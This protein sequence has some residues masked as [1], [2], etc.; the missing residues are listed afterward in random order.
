MPVTVQ[1]LWVL[2]C[3]ILLSACSVQLAPGY[4]AALTEGLSE[5]NGEALTLFAALEEGSPASEF[6]NYQERYAEL[7]GGFDG[8]RQRAEARPVP[9][10]AQRLARHRIVQGFC[11]SRDDP[12]A[13]LN[14]SPA[15][16]SEIVS[17]LRQLRTRHRTNG[18]S[19]A[20]VT[21]IRNGYDVAIHQALTVESALQR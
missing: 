13:C 5:A 9:P 21:Q 18:V 17:L 16:L 7:I 12:A 8:L 2:L 15:S 11:N 3:A 6:A 4:D 1:R 19:P 10:M 20:A 14:S